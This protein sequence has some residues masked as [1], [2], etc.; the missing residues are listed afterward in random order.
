MYTT[1]RQCSIC[2]KIISERFFV[3]MRCLRAHG[4]SLH[5][6]EYPQWLKQLIRI[7]ARDLRLRRRE[8]DHLS[9]E[10]LDAGFYNPKPEDT[11]GL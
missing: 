9:L 6:R 7:D 11:R 1:R 4:I 10:M 2:G 5:Y 8:I 3:C